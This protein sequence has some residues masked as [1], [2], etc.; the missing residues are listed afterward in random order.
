MKP[1]K[2][3]ET[4]ATGHTFDDIEQTACACGTVTRLPLQPAPSPADIKTRAEERLIRAALR[5]AKDWVTW[6]RS[7]DDTYDTAMNLLNAVRSVQRERKKK[8]VP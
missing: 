1:A 8:V 7:L 2:T 4:C 6:G 3:K 5:W